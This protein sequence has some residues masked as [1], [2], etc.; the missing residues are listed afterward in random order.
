M[1]KSLFPLSAQKHFTIGW[2]LLFKEL[3]AKF[4]RDL[5]NNPQKLLWH[6]TIW[7]TY[8]PMQTEVLFKWSNYSILYFSG[9]V[10]KNYNGLVNIRLYYWLGKLE[11]IKVR[12]WKWKKRAHCTARCK[13]TNLGKN[14]ELW[15]FSTTSEVGSQS[16]ERRH[17]RVDKYK[18]TE[19][20]SNTV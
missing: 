4:E 11:V 17:I 7:T 8:S 6:K 19:N 16:W 18:K 10:Q 3:Q 2:L 12:T 9:M 20:Q 15:C 14:G 5:C 13:W 1:R